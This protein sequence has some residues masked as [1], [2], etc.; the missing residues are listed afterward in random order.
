MKKMKK[1]S[2]A[3]LAVLLAAGMAGCSEAALWT[4]TTTTANTTTTT[5]AAATTIEIN[6]TTSPTVAKESEAAIDH[7]ETRAKP[8]EVT[9]NLPEFVVDGIRFFDVKLE[10]RGPTADRPVN[11]QVYGKVENISEE[12]IEFGF[13]YSLFYEDKEPFCNSD[14]SNFNYCLL[15]GESMSF[16]EFTTSLVEAPKKIEYFQIVGLVPAEPSIETLYPDSEVDTQN[17]PNNPLISK[18]EFEQIKN[19]MSYEE[20][21][22]IIGSEGEVLSEVGSEGEDY[23]TIIYMWDGDGEIGANANFTFQKGKLVGKAQYGLD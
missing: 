22:K 23:H 6:E 15:P 10:D 12:T 3:M 8:S 4:T 20:V 16:S 13:E 21:C 9:D 5:T 17:P 18:A 7:S 2:L 19:G 1:L 11:I 14:P